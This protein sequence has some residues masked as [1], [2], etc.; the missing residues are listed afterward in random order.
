MKT[1]M[2]EFIE[3]LKKEKDEHGYEKHP[4]FECAIEHAESMLEKEDDVSKQSELL[5]DFRKWWNEDN[6]GVCT[7]ITHKDIERYLES[8]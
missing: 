5:K 8:L 3:W 2:Q 1:P 6:Q 7:T 4:Y